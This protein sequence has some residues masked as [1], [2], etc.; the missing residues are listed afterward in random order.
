MQTATKCWLSTIVAVGALVGCASDSPEISSDVLAGEDLLVPIPRELDDEAAMKRSEI[1]GKS[2]LRHG[3]SQSTSF[4]L[5]V[6]RS[7]LEQKWFWS[8]YLKELQPYGP[9]PRTLG[10]KVVR[11]R[12]QNDKLFVFDAD[13]RRATSDVFHPDLIIDA[14]PIVDDVPFHSLPGSGNYVLIDPGAG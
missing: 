10:T 11:F 12:I 2:E 6:R 3:N 5:A 8:V 9:S 4:Y 1:A 13:D 7:A 14:F